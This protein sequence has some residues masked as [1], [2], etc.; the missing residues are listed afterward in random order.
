MLTSATEPSGVGSSRDDPNR[1]RCSV[2]RMG[3][4][5]GGYRHKNQGG[6]HNAQ[7]DPGEQCCARYA[8]QV[9]N[10]QCNHGRDGNR[11]GVGRGHIVPEGQS[12]SCAGR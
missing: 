11:H 3:P 1:A 10:R 9:H 8:E 5:D 7:E 12:H 2:G 4:D 6:Q